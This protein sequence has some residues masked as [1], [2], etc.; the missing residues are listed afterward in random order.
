MAHTFTENLFSGPIA[1]GRD[2]LSD[3]LIGVTTDDSVSDRRG[4]RLIPHDC[5]RRLISDGAHPSRTIS[6]VAPCAANCGAS[7]K[8]GPAF[9][10]TRLLKASNDNTPDYFAN[11]NYSMWE[12]WTD[13][14]RQA[15]IVQARS[16]CL[17]MSA[18]FHAK[19]RGAKLCVTPSENTPE[20]FRDNYPP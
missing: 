8:A 3:F 20:N 17:L 6:G 19:Q 7:V 14:D 9:S 4:A 12:R 15:G 2:G 11:R 10:F 1:I 18:V 16:L 13:L 5:G